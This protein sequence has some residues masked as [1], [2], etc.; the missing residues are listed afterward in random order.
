M[1]LLKWSR[2][3]VLFIILV[4][5][6]PLVFGALPATAGNRSVSL[7]GE[8]KSAS[9]FVINSITFTVGDIGSAIDRE[10]ID[11][12]KEALKGDSNPNPTDQQGV[13]ELNRLVATQVTGQY[14]DSNAADDD[15]EFRRAP[16]NG[17]GSDTSK[18]VWSFEDNQ[19]EVQQ[20][21]VVLGRVGCR[22]IIDNED[23]VYSLSAQDRIYEAALFRFTN[24]TTIIRTDGVG[25][26]FQSDPSTGVTNTFYSVNERGQDN[27][28]FV[29]VGSAVSGAANIS[30]ATYDHQTS[31]KRTGVNWRIFTLDSSGNPT[32][33]TVTRDDTDGNI[34][35]V[36]E[37]GD[38]C[39]DTGGFSF[40]LCPLLLMGTESIEIVDERIIN[41]LEVN[42]KYY[43]GPELK[44]AW[45]RIR[46]IGYILLIPVLLIMV[47]S[48]A[49]GFNFV[50]AYTVKRAMPR[51]LVAVI[52]MALSFNICVFL[53]QLTNDIG[54]GV[55]GI[56]AAPFGG[57]D[58][59]ELQDVFSSGE[60]VAVTGIAAVGFTAVMFALVF[61]PA[62]LLILFSY[63]A[64]AALALIVVFSLLT[65]REMIILFLI[66]FSPIAIVSWIFPGNDK[67]WKLWW[68]TF[69][70]LLMIFPVIVALLWFGRGFAKIIF[71]SD[72]GGIESV[73]LM[74]A[75]FIAYIGPFFFIPAAFKFA[76]GAFANLSGMVNDRSKGL[77]DRNKKFRAERYKKHGK[78][79]KE[80]TFVKRGMTGGQH[81]GHSRANRVNARIKALANID[82]AFEGEND[83]SSPGGL[84]RSVRTNVGAAIKRNLGA[85]QEHFEKDP[86][87]KPTLHDDQSGGYVS[88]STE[89][90]FENEDKLM[91]YGF[92]VD[93]ETGVVDEVKLK[94]TMDKIKSQRGAG[95]I[96]G[97]Y[98]TYLNAANDKTNA[99]STIFDGQ[100][101][102]AGE[103]EQEVNDSVTNMAVL[104]KRYDK[105]TLETSL[106]Q[107]AAAGGTYYQGGEAALLSLAAATKGDLN[108][109][110]SGAVKMRAALM[111]TG[112]TDQGAISHGKAFAIREMANSMSKGAESGDYTQMQKM[113]R[114]QGYEDEKITAVDSQS[115]DENAK[116]IRE[117]LNNYVANTVYEQQGAQ[118]LT[119][120]AIKTERVIKNMLPQL[121]RNLEIA[122]RKA[123]GELETNPAYSDDQNAAIEKYA[124]QLAGAANIW[125]SLQG[126]KPEVAR[127]LAPKFIGKKLASGK[128][129]GETIDIAAATSDTYRQ[130][131][132]EFV[133][134]AKNI[135]EMERQIQDLRTR[136]GPGVEAQIAQ[137]QQ[138]MVAAGAAAGLG[139]A[140]QIEG[141]DIAQGL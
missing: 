32:G 126:S 76:G 36:D 93:K 34:N 96:S 69:S 97:A 8:F 109:Y 13:D 63:I 67:L 112:R 47:I 38:S 57:K 11:D 75:K 121:E 120:T 59:L 128:T 58:A 53:I 102:A 108:A 77:F 12:L 30:Q 125:Q 66:I 106:A 88:I 22:D 124:S 6:L 118:T 81:H 104:A 1:R 14:I 5:L 89:R 55:G 65:I 68:G 42:E 92:A 28:D 64:G 23:L 29:S 127:L 115:K 18:F 131:H 94:A 101:N 80:G 84:A 74:F 100:D 98:R 17:C 41:S 139:E 141:T 70:K 7:S 119:H 105:E 136:G 87:T 62:T 117:V 91:D 71:V 132:K 103:V 35:G 123:G 61:N 134:K 49:L 85:E 27:Q 50:E 95:D 16:V 24:P 133:G 99:F 72:V 25:G 44:A 140:Q 110:A 10:D 46:D 138:Q 37:E 135:E 60:G 82:K 3:Y 129:V 9:E 43:S 137:L 15:R 45:S 111:Q 39:N 31:D 26:E 130:Y 51:L 113:M 73:F 52:F 79:L 122:E 2:F 4:L 114:D 56:I 86:D 33:D 83:F 116:M 107:R 54:N 20:L 19:Y 21:Y 78:E 40:L 48:T 90:F